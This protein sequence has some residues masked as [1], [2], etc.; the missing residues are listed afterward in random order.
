MTSGISGTPLTINLETKKQK[1]IQR[2]Q[3]QR[4]HYTHTVST[5]L[6]KQE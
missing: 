1:E 3:A 5:A 2:K 6:I 4:D